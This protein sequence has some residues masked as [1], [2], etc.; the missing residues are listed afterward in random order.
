[1]ARNTTPAASSKEA[2]VD[3]VAIGQTMEAANSLAVIERSK[4][5]MLT[6]AEQE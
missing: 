5:E 2:I 1:M 4:Q 6:Q 3:A